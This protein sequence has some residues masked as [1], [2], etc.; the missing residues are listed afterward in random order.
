MKNAFNFRSG[1]FKAIIAAVLAC[2]LTVSCYDDSKLW[3]E[4]DMIVD[5]L[6]ELEQKMNSE[7]KALKSML[8]G[9]VFISDVS[10]DAST[11]I[12]TIT[13]SDGLELELLPEKELESY[14]TYMTLGDGKEYWAYIDGN[15]TKQ[16]FLDADGKAVPVI[17][18][19]PE[20][21]TEGEDT[22]L[23]IGGMKYP[24][25]GNSVFSDYE[26]IQ[27]E[28][29]GEVYAVTFT[30]GEDMTFTVTVDGACGFYFVKPAGWSTTVVSDWYVANGMTERVQVDARGVV[31]YVLQ[32][33]DGWRVKEYEEIYMGG[34]YFDITA[35]S[36]DLVESGVAAAEGDLKVVAVLE[37]GKATVSR[38]YL[39]TTPFRSFGVSLG[40]VN[41]EMYNGLQK[42]V[43]GVCPVAEFNEDSIFDTASELLNA[44]D[45][46]A[47]FGVSSGDLSASVADVLGSEPYSGDSYVFWALPALYYQ[48][49]DDS[50]YYLAKE[51]F[52][53]SEF[54]FVSVEFEVYDE[55]FRDA[56]LS[57]EVRG[58]DSYYM[59]LTPVTDF[60]L[61]DVLYNLNNSYYEPI[62]EPMMYEGSV[63]GLMDASAEA[64]TAYVVWIALHESGKTY[65]EADVIVREFSTLKIEPGGDVKVVAGDVT[66]SALD[67]KVPLT[68]EGAEKIYYSFM[69]VSDAKKYADDASKASYL[70][71][72]GLNVADTYVEAALSDMQIKAKP[73]TAYVLFAVASDSEGKYGE[74]LT[75]EYKTTEVAYNDLEVELSVVT[76]DPGNVVLGVS[77]QGAVDFLYWVGKTSDNTWKSSNYLGG[78]AETAQAWMYLNSNHSRLL[79]VMEKYPI[80]DGTIVLNDLE[81]DVDHVIVVMAKDTDGTYSRAFELRFTTRPVTIGNIVLSSD[82]KWEAAKPTLKWLEEYF[83]QSSGGTLPGSY[84]FEITVPMGYTAY[85]LAAT[86]SYLNNGDSTYIPTVEE[87]IITIIQWTDRGRDWHLT[88]SDD[89]V[90][91]HI[92]YDHYRSEHGAPLWGNSVIWASQEFHDSVCDCGGTFTAPRDINGYEVMVSHIININE[93][94][95]FEFRQPSA[96][97]STQEVIDK[98]FVVCQD[99]DGNCYEK[100]VY[101]VP[102]ELFANAG[103]RDE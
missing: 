58:A 1:L 37:G 87:E 60:L 31:D 73:S 66:P 67:L 32:I 12:T 103:G 45:Y 34:L 7:I 68:A 92:G 19:V 28:L 80:V 50:G 22:Y 82:P 97:A 63:F 69:S 25:S 10:T 24:L 36:R 59:G 51:T 99:L 3:K 9:Q 40:N 85:V 76:N 44:Y 88:T 98:V 91:P 70:F 4:I 64:A 42:F 49:A 52:V 23:V 55:K 54:T 18:D 26:I 33:P 48:T 93:G 5:Q 53:T 78:S 77:A 83:T 94:K 14:V 72:N 39:T 47:G 16:L 71:E 96:I 100:F 30:F 21:V 57:M 65:T 74:V 90:W 84:G 102:V 62:V 29:T 61:D 89:W 79:T 95:P 46:P 13:L 17:S 86:D 6:F 2:P 43:Y 101:D 27:D 20:V 81:L 35:P 11:G 38:L 15:G 8:T 56:T 75:V 41:A